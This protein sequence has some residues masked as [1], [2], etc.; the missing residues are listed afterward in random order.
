MTIFSPLTILPD[1]SSDFL[2]FDSITLLPIFAM[3]AQSVDNLDPRIAKEL[4]YLGNTPAWTCISDNRFCYFLYVPQNYHSLTRLDLM[5][6]IHSS[7]RNASEIRREFAQFAEKHPCIVLAPLFPIEPDD[8]QDRAGYKLLKSGNV[9]YDRVL[10]S[11]VDEVHARFEHIEVE[12]FLLFGFSGGAQFVHRFAYLYPQRLKVMAC[13][14]PGAQTLLDYSRPYPEGV[15]D[16]AQLFGQPFQPQQLCSV[17]TMFIVGGADTDNFYAS[18][19]GRS[20]DPSIHNGRY[21][22]ITRLEESWR[23]A[24]IDCHLHVVPGVS[25]QQEPMLEHIVAFF[26]IHTSY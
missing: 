2:S 23:A 18:A 5:I 26:Q 19:R 12:R 21:G 3:N 6:L 9:R 7:G 14:A 10:L 25:H 24:G 4:G 15:K 17:P 8:P 1:V 22:G 13:G 20:L 11:M 16:L